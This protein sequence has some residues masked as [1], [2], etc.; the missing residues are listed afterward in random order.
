MRVEHGRWKVGV[1]RESPTWQGSTLETPWRG[2]FVQVSYLSQLTPSLKA[3][4]YEHLNL[5]GFSPAVTEEQEKNLFLEY[6]LIP[7]RVKR[8]VQ[9]AHRLY[10]WLYVKCGQEE[11]PSR[12][13]A[14]VNE[15]LNPALRGKMSPKWVDLIDQ[16]HKEIRIP[17]R[18]SG[19]SLFHLS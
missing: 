6:P 19:T 10:C 1:F 16:F 11:D 12:L 5:F 3:P 9:V 15:F 8:L 14:V 4:K 13:Q 7:L 17:R 2:H 18:T